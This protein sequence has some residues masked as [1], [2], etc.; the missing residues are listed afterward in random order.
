MTG[1]SP[2]GS[3]GFAGDPTPLGVFVP[4]ENLVVGSTGVVPEP[5][6]LLLFALGGL[7][8]GV[9]SLRRRRREQS[10]AFRETP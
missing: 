9:E 3:G 8:C 5:T 10:L 7:A 6:T 2:L 1:L 4:Q